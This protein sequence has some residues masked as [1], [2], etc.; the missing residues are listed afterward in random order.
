MNTRK[1]NTS[2]KGLPG[3][4]PI[5][6]KLGLSQAKV[7][8]LCGSNG[9]AEDYIR[10]VE[11][12]LADCSQVVQRELAEALCC[13]VADLHSPELSDERLDKIKNAFELR[14]AQEVLARQAQ[15]K[16]AGAA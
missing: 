16:K 12:G 4:F 3:L 10:H 5:R 13:T 11:G 2:G 6:E 1:K 9:R 14:N 8:A 15:D 7:G